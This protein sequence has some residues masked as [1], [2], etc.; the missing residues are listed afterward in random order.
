VQS[1]LQAAGYDIGQGYLFSRPM[2]LTECCAWLSDFNA[3]PQ[4]VAS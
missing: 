1:Y 4:R 2:A 3:A